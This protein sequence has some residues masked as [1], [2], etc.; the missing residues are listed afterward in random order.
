MT[1]AARE[2]IRRHG[3]I[4]TARLITQDTEF[5]GMR[6]KQGEQILVPNHLY[7]LHER[8]VDNP[9]AADF[10]RPHP[11]RHYAAFGNGPHR[12]PGSFLAKLELTVFLQERL[13]RIPDFT[14]KPGAPPR[15][16]S[17]PVNTTHEL[18]IAW[19]TDPR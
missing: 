3:L 1:N 5:Q 8:Q 11:E 13:A 6:L 15:M 7:G 16:A 14:I 2:L 19:D 12:R 18:H 4:N 17:G 9:L 10:T